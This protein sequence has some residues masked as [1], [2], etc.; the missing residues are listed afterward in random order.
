[1]PINGAIRCEY[2]A[3]FLRVAISYDLPITQ[4][5]RESLAFT[6]ASC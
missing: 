6:A 2:S 5:D 3:K 1:M 4:E